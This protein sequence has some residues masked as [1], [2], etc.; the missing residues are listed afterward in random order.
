MIGITICHWLPLA[1]NMLPE[2]EKELKALWNH[3]DATQSDMRLVLEPKRDFQGAIYY[4]FEWYSPAGAFSAAGKIDVI[5]FVQHVTSFTTHDGLLPYQIGT[6]V[7]QFSSLINRLLIRI[8]PRAARNKIAVLAENVLSRQEFEAADDITIDFDPSARNFLNAY[9]AT[10]VH[11]HSKNVDSIMS[12]N[13]PSLG[14]FASP[15]THPNHAAIN[16]TGAQLIAIS[17]SSSVEINKRKIDL[18]NPLNFLFYNENYDLQSGQNDIDIDTVFF[19]YLAAVIFLECLYRTIEILKAVRDHLTVERRALVVNLRQNTEDYFPI[20]TKIKRYLTYVDI[21]I[22]VI[23]KV[24]GHIH[25]ITVATPD[26]QSTNAKFGNAEF[27]EIADV[28]RNLENSRDFLDIELIKRA[29]LKPE[30]LLRR[31]HLNSNRLAK[32]YKEE[33]AEA[34]VLS[35]ELSQVLDGTLLAA[36]REIMSRELD[37]SRS[38]LE[39][40][41]GGKNRGNALKFLSVVT[42]AGLGLTVGGEAASLIGWLAKDYLGNSLE[43]SLIQFI[44]SA[45]FVTMMKVIF[46]FF[47]YLTAQVYT[48]RFI[49]TRANSYRLLIPINRIFPVEVLREL[50][51]NSS[52]KQMDSYGNRRIRRW[53]KKLSVTHYRKKLQTPRSEKT[54]EFDITI[55]YEKRGFVHSLMLETESKQVDFSTFPLVGQ[56]VLLFYVDGKLEDA[57]NYWE[58]FPKDTSFFVESL[59]QLGVDFDD[60]LIGLNRVLTLPARELRNQLRLF[61]A[62]E[63]DSSLSEDDRAELKDICSNQ[64]SYHSRLQEIRGDP[65]LLRLVGEDNLDIKYSL[66]SEYA[67]NYPVED[68]VSENQS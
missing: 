48:N 55:D 9:R 11:L 21:K 13:V 27:K 8:L 59:T 23:G 16:D 24:A 35:D 10:A 62:N 51:L 63:A 65:V 45:E 3:R 26:S 22:P 19:K 25:D 18:V 68:E 66:I 60:N 36:S 52:L 28:I 47:A 49:A 43:P 15:A 41:R 1:E 44:G 61:R 2:I 50:T 67:I 64:I 4:Q 12:L 7:E 30:D 5:G 56:A 53:K 38:T 40:D 58:Y 32:L 46:A 17:T 14:L 20:L 54:I 6:G 37:T 42:A 34:D 31:I 29:E 39:I 57:K 33:E